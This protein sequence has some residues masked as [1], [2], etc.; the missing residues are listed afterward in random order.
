MDENLEKCRVDQ[1]C[2]VIDELKK[3]HFHRV[4]GFV[5]HLSSRSF[6]VCTFS[7]NDLEYKSTNLKKLASKI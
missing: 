2:I 6:Q 7:S 3:K 1:A 5:F 4:A